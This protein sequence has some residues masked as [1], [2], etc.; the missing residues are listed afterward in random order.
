MRR[1]RQS[2]SGNWPPCY[3]QWRITT[4]EKTGLKDSIEKLI[5]L[6]F[7]AWNSSITKNGYKIEP[8]G[9]V[10]PYERIKKSITENEAYQT[11]LIE[12]LKELPKMENQKLIKCQGECVYKDNPT[13]ELS[14][15]CYLSNCEYAQKK[16]WSNNSINL[17]K[18]ILDLLTFITFLTLKKRS[19]A[20]NQGEC[21]MPLLSESMPLS[22]P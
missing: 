19:K 1:S 6:Y 20:T 22:P 18:S 16:W 5:T 17:K 7:T 4:A 8:I 10:D 14:Y 3:E 11:A 13:Y 9:N 21:Y 2:V 15:W 12:I